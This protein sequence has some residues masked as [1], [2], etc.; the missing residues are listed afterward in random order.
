MDKEE[1]KAIAK[2][3]NFR[4]QLN[5]LLRHYNAEIEVEEDFDKSTSWQTSYK[6]VV[7]FKTEDGEWYI[8]DIDLGTSYNGDEVE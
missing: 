3:T 1:E 7:T 2:R 4:I 8:E 6:V 5:A